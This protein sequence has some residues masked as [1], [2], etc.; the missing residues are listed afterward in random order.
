MEGLVVLLQI[1]P[2][3]LKEASDYIEELMRFRWSS[4]SHQ[5]AKVAADLGSIA[6]LKSAD[7]DWTAT[8][9]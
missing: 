4:L 5:T 1:S 9:S 3:S 2:L 7:N 8:A 6:T